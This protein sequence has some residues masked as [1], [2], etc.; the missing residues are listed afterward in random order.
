ME[1]LPNISGPFSY[2]SATANYRNFGNYYDREDMNMGN[3]YWSEIWESA[4][5][6][7][8]VL[9][10][11]DGQKNVQKSMVVRSNGECPSEPLIV[12]PWL[13]FQ[14]SQENPNAKGTWNPRVHVNMDGLPPKE[15]SGIAYMG[16]GIGTA[17]FSTGD[18]ASRSVYALWDETRLHWGIDA[19]KNKTFTMKPHIN[20]NCCKTVMEETYYEDNYKEFRWTASLNCEIIGTVTPPVCCIFDKRIN[21]DAK[22]FYGSGQSYEWDAQFRW[23]QQNNNQTEGVNI[24][25]R[26]HDF[27]CPCVSVYESVENADG[28]TT[29]VLVEYREHEH[30]FC[31]CSVS[32]AGPNNGKTYWRSKDLG[33]GLYTEVFN[34]H[35]YVWSSAHGTRDIAGGATKIYSGETFKFWFETEYHSNRDSLPDA[36]HEPFSQPYTTYQG[37]QGCHPCNYLSRWP[38]VYNVDGPRT[39]DLKISGSQNYDME[40]YRIGPQYTVQNGAVH[41]QYRW[42]PVPDE[43]FVPETQIVG[44]QIKLYIC[45]YDFLGHYQDS[46]WFAGGSSPGYA[47]YT[48]AKQA[49]CDSKS[50]IISL[51]PSKMYISSGQEAEGLDTSS[52]GSQEGENFVDGDIWVQ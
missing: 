44:Q 9:D 40:K 36:K 33:Y 1:R 41:K 46:S 34:I 14:I 52:G 32:H 8:F 3:N 26:E 23:S 17:T 27:N 10:I 16:N 31:Y 42:V 24:K 6:P 12:Y 19:S 5:N 22:T 43:I 47:W 35:I 21:Q 11:V 48:R 51:A 28:S 39:I 15:V 4:K 50:G 45:V 29:S 13:E 30:C 37:G 38:G 25:P 7:N 20:Y 49:Y 2:L 18:T